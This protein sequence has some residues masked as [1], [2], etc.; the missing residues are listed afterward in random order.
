MKS[1]VDLT[2][3]LAIQAAHEPEPKVGTLKWPMNLKFVQKYNILLCFG[4]NAG[5]VPHNGSFSKAFRH[6][7]VAVSSNE[8]CSRRGR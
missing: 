2:D 4:G 7:R 5:K 3:G 1:K 8:M 6:C